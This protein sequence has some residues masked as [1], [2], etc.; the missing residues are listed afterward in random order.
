[1]TQKTF[2][3]FSETAVSYL[4]STSVNEYMEQ[5]NYIIRGRKKN[6]K[7]LRSKS[8]GKPLEM[9]AEQI[10]TIQNKLKTAKRKYFTTTKMWCI[11][12]T[13]EEREQ[14][15]AQ[16]RKKQGRQ[17]KKEVSVLRKQK[18]LCTMENGVPVVLALIK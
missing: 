3:Q 9:N 5:N 14:I 13:P 12:L 4:N 7:A 8:I 15:L 18:Y 17:V 16:G 10:V 11:G 1:M 6:V 2:I